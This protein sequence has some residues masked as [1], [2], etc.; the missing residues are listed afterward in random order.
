MLFTHFHEKKVVLFSCHCLQ[1]AIGMMNLSFFWSFEVKQKNHR[2]GQVA[3]FM[4]GTFISGS[5]MIGTF[6]IGSFIIGA[7]AWGVWW[8]R[9]FWSFVSSRVSKYNFFFVPFCFHFS[10]GQT[11]QRLAASVFLYPLTAQKPCVLMIFYWNYEL[12]NNFWHSCI[13]ILK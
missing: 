12:F 10:Q 9:C 2:K 1:F 3:A 7:V 6:I 4:I 11:R 5:F 13:I 8:L